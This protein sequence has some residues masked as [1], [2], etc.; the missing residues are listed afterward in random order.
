MKFSFWS[1]KTITVSKKLMFNIQIL[2]GTREYIEVN[3]ES[4]QTSKM[5]LVRT[6]IGFQ[7][8]TIFAKSF[9]LNVWKVSKSASGIH[10]SLLVLTMF[11]LIMLH[12]FISL[13]IV[14]K[15]KCQRVVYEPFAMCAYIFFYIRLC[16]KFKWKLAFF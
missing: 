8:L 7:P 10:L 13:Q 11:Y 3:S 15:S 5:E 2:K 14:V 1:K 9:I 12:G 6:D 4:C 16:F